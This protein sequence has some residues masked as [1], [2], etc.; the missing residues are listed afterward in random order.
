MFIFQ[1]MHLRGK[2]IGSA[3]KRRQKMIFA[4]NIRGIRE[5]GHRR[6]GVKRI[7]GLVY[8]ET[9]DALRDF[10]TSVISDAV[11]YCENARRRTV[12][13]FGCRLRFEAPRRE[14]CMASAK[15]A[16]QSFR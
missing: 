14:L 9:R 5:A 16:R 7:S 2:G 1:Q 8:E 3:H 10:L 4:A 13:H 6:A 12:T 15:E 11:T